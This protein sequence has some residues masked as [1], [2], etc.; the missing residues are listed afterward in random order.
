MFTINHLIFVAHKK[1][2]LILGTCNC[3]VTRLWETKGQTK[4]C[5]DL[6]N[7]RA[8]KN[9]TVKNGVLNVYFVASEQLRSEGNRQN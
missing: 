1:G 4:K 8:K 5:I 3:Q 7:V 6:G 9:I 2:K